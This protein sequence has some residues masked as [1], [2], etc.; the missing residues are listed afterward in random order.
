[1]TN[2]EI[3]GVTISLTTDELKIVNKALSDLSYAIYRGRASKSY[4]DKGEAV[5][6]VYEKISKVYYD[7]ARN[8]EG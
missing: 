5:D 1:M 8:V 6:A 7:M 3:N 2:L 4:K